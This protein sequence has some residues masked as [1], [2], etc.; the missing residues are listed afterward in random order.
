MLRGISYCCRASQIDVACTSGC[1]CSNDNHTPSQLRGLAP[2]TRSTENKL[3][4]HGDPVVFMLV[5]FRVSRDG[6][7]KLAENIPRVSVSSGSKAAYGGA[8]KS[9]AA[10]GT[11]FVVSNTESHISN[12][13]YKPPGCT[14]YYTFVPADI[15]RIHRR[16]RVP[17]KTP[18]AKVFFYLLLILKIST[19]FSPPQVTLLPPAHSTLQFDDCISTRSK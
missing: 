9:H 6:S 12:T 5:V 1:C 11:A 2:P 18:L 3:D 17:G 14:W 8:M 7:I 13:M 15:L 19:A 10:V 16:V 4:N